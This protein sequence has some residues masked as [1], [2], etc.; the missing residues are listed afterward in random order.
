[1]MGSG[2]GSFLE[3]L[4]KGAS[5]RRQMEAGALEEERMQ[6]AR[7]EDARAAE[8]F[9][10]FKKDHEYEVSKRA[11][12]DTEHQQDRDY[13]L[14]ERDYQ[15]RQRQLNAPAEQARREGVMAETDWKKLLLSEAQKDAPVKDLRRKKDTLQAES[16]IQT[17][18]MARKDQELV[19]RSGQEA[20]TRYNETVDKSFNIEKNDNG[21]DV[22]VFDGKKYASPDEAKNA[23]RQKN[24][25][26]DNYLRS[27]QFNEI[28]NND[29]ANG[30]IEEAKKK[31]EWTKFPGVRAGIETSGRILQAYTI[32]DIDAVN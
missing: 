3:G 28:I 14:S 11:R 7:N 27:P 16:E 24:P 21:A 2:I 25:F 13:T 30:R 8:K 20:L 12:D 5:L 29:I 22:Y 23:Y 15:E 19:Q 1:M 17:A 31:M 4:A 6:L 26:F 18:E 32:G 9:D 10:L